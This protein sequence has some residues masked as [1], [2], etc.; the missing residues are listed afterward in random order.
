MRSMPTSRPIRV[1]SWVVLRKVLGMDDRLLLSSCPASPG[2]DLV[3]DHR[4]RICWMDQVERCPGIS[5][6]LV[7]TTTLLPLLQANVQCD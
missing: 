3:V 7:L 6:I 5:L 1:V 2:L 4:D